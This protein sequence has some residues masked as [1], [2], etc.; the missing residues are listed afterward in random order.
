[1]DD[2]DGDVEEVDDV[3]DDVADDDVEAAPAAPVPGPRVSVPTAQSRARATTLPALR[4]VEAA[5]G[6]RSA[7]ALDGAVDRPCRTANTPVTLAVPT[8][9]RTGEFP[10]PDV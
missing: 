1:V 6:R 5:R 2:P 3:V 10:C 8:T 7:G 9:R 4:A